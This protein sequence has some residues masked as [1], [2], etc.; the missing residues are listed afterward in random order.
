MPASSLNTTTALVTG[1]SRG[2][3]RATAVALHEAAP[4]SSPW[5][6][7]LARWTSC[8]PS[9]ASHLPSSRRTP[10]TRSWPASSS[11]STVRR[12]LC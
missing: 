1:A 11:S 12:R 6:A 8:K 10:P 5:R 7:T 4:E 9:S 2:F 3:G